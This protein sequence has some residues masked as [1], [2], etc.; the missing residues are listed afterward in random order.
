VISWYLRL[1][2]V[3]S[4]K[5]FSPT[6]RLLRIHF[7]R[8]KNPDTQVLYCYDSYTISKLILGS[9][10]LNVKLAVAKLLK[11]LHGIPNSSQLGLS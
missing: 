8:V 4:W 6:D 11:K 2:Y 5:V 9:R 10:S 7:G 3:H 1:G